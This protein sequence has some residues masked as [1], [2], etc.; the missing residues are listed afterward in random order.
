MKSSFELLQG[1]TNQV[2]FRELDHDRRFYED[3]DS[4]A[5]KWLLKETYETYLKYKNCFRFEQI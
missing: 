1:L 2:K 3:L 5:K 4:M